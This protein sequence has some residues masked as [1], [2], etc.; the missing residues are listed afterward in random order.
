MSVISSLSIL[1]SKSST[2]S[3]SSHP[4]SSGYT[5]SPVNGSRSS[6]FSIVQGSAL[7]TSA[8]PL[9]ADALGSTAAA[10]PAITTNIAVIAAEITNTSLSFSGFTAVVVIL[11]GVPLAVETHSWFEYPN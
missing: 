6:P 2:I 11:V 5:I 8:S 9:I 1:S 4:S 10:P 3:S 7:D